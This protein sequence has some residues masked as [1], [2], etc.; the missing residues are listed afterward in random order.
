MIC[1]NCEQYQASFYVPNDLEDLEY[2]YWTKKQVKYLCDE[3]CYEYQDSHKY[4]VDRFID[5]G[6]N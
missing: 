5:S 1:N 2:N 3:C 4:L 6:L